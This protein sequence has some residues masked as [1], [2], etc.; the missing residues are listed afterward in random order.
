MI[1]VVTEPSVSSVVSPVVDTVRVAVPLVGMVTV[2]LPV[3]TP[4]LPDAVTF[5]VTVSELDGVGL[6]VRVNEAALPSVTSLP[7]VILTTGVGG[8]SSSVMFTV[9]EA[10]VE[11][12]S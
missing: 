3:V 8:L 4:K 5:T 2:R 12:T 7:A 10:A 11:S 9:A 6:A 1:V